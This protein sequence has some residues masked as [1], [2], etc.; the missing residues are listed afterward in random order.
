MIH[1]IDNVFF[2][3]QKEKYGKPANSIQATVMMAFGR[4]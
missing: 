4:K 1:N 3:F 2:Y